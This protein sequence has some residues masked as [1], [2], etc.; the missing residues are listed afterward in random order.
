[1][2]DFLLYI[3]VVSFTL[4]LGIA[5]PIQRAM[6]Q[7][8]PSGAP[9]AAVDLATK[10]GVALVKGQWRYSDTKIIE[11]AFKA[12][13]ADSTASRSMSRVTSTSRA[14][15]DSGCFHPRAS[16]WAPSSRPGILTTWPGAMPTAR[17]CT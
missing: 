8:V 15:A 10:E 16:I 13:G 9:S 1:M 3:L 6:A 4:G 11:V 5:L 7:E 2:K 12:A 14:R 17:H